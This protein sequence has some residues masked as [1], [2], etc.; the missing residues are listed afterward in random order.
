M[1]FIFHNLNI[2]YFCNFKF[3]NRFL[4]IISLFTTLIT[5][6]LD[7]QQKCQTKKMKCIDAKF[8]HL[9]FNSCVEKNIQFFSK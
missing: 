7:K 9:N 8:K 2:I 5:I 1:H 3:Y 6:I 4:L